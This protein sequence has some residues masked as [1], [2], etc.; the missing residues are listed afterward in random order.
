MLTAS[1]LVL[2]VPITLAIVSGRRA[3]AIAIYALAALTDFF[4]GKV[5]RR[6]G[7]ASE[8][9]S[10][11]DAGVDIAFSAMLFIWL[12]I[13]FPQHARTFWFLM[14]VILLANAL[15]GVVAFYRTGR[16]LSLHLMP[17]KIG[18]AVLFIA[19]P[20]AVLIGYPVQVVSAAS[21]IVLCGRVHT[22]VYILRTRLQELRSE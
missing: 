2:I 22:L 18:T 5:A 13:L 19:F 14:A 3:L 6:F 4:D 21:A 11:F 15:V 8:F 1:R 12:L 10:K 17:S 16:L 7:L 20:L 9:G